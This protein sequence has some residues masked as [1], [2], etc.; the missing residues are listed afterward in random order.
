MKYVYVQN[1]QIVSG[2]KALP[3]A[4]KNISGLNLMADAALAALGWLPWRVVDAGSPGQDWAESTPTVEIKSTEVV[5]T[6]TYR[7]KTQEEIEVEKQLTSVAN[8]NLRAKAYVEESDP[9]FFKA[10][11]GEATTEEWL[12]K[13]E[14]IKVRYPT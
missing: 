5:E 6:K 14:E 10:Q 11:R 1:G 4:W 9:L 3:K 13:V 12:A 8:K 2:P 7:Q